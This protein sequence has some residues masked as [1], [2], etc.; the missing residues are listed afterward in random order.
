MARRRNCK[1]DLHTFLNNFTYPELDVID[2]Y[3]LIGDSIIRNV[4]NINNT[5]VIAYPGSNLWK[6][7][8]LIEHNRLTEIANKKMVIVHLGTNDASRPNITVDKL[9]EL[10]KNLITQIRRVAPNA[11]VAFSHVIPRPCDFPKTHELVKE[12]NKFVQA[13]AAS[14]GIRTFPSYSTLQK[15][16]KPIEKYYKTID[17]LHLNPAGVLRMR[18]SLSKFIAKERIRCGFRRTRRK[19]PETAVR[20]SLAAVKRRNQRK[21]AG[22]RVN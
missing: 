19:A 15:A 7:A 2:E 6:M 8:L 21:Y 1:W 10:T 13:N 16:G 5:Q 12:Y 18:M 22:N 17:R 14:W 11:V 20:V 4:G 9:V 3:V